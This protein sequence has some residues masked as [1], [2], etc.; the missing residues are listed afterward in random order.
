[1]VAG[2]LTDRFGNRL[3]IYG[4]IAILAL[5]FALMPWAGVSFVGAAAALAVWGVCGWGF[6][7]AQQHRLVGIAPTLSAILQGR[8]RSHHDL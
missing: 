2:G 1:M 6:V 5:D 3:V 7:V 8:S 4:R